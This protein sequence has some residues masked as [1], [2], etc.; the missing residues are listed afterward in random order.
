[1]I[2]DVPCPKHQAWGAGEHLSGETALMW[3]GCCSREEGTLLAAGGRCVVQMLSN[4]WHFVTPRTATRQAHCPSLFP[5]VCS[6]SYP[7][8]WWCNTTISSSVAPFFSCSQSFPSSGSF[9]ISQ[10]FMSDGQRTGTSA[11]ASVLPIN[12]QGWFPLGLTGFISLQ[13]KGLSRVFSSTTVQK[14]QFFSAQPSL[15]SNSYIHT[16]LLEKT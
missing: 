7:L 13:S 5:E 8:S 16:W 12:T 2:L 10:L 9:P 11:T 1:M 3:W 6:N 14:H 15:W 4:V